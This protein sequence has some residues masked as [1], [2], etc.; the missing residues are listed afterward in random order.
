MTT[1]F[2]LDEHIS[3]RAARVLVEAG[4]DTTCVNGSFLTGKSDD[5]VLEAAIAEGRILVT[6]NRSDFEPLLAG[7]I[8][9]KAALP[10]LV[11]VHRPTWPTERPEALATELVSLAKRIDEG[12][13]SAAYGLILSRPR[14]PAGTS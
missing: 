2:L 6:Y 8:A 7:Y 11:F 13:Q 3:P 10:G 4:I 5:L 14:G 12:R 9:R 1:K